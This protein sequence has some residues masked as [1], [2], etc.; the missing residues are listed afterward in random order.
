MTSEQTLGENTRSVAQTSLNCSF[1]ATKPEWNALASVDVDGRL[2]LGP[3]GEVPAQSKTLAEVQNAIAEKGGMPPSEVTAIQHE[4]RSQCLTVYGPERNRQRNVGYR[5]PE[6]VLELLQ[7]TGALQPGCCDTRD[8]A[9]VRANVAVGVS[10]TGSALRRFGVGDRGK[11][12]TYDQ[13][14]VATRLDQIHVGETRQSRV[15]AAATL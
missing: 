15:T 11:E 1:Y 10:P 14:G 2:P 9:V 12:Q 7:R 5:G 4:A 3:L 13:R 6:R 8:L